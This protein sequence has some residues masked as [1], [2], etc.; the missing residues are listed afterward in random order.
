MPHYIATEQHHP[1]LLLFIGPAIGIA[2]SATYCSINI[3][4]IKVA[5]EIDVNHKENVLE[6]RDLSLCNESL[7]TLE[8]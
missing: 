5:G 3:K 8:R 7:L 2:S 1:F 6:T 4:A